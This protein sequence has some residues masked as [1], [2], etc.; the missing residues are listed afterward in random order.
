MSGRLSARAA[1]GWSAC[2]GNCFRQPGGYLPS[3]VMATQNGQTA[4]VAAV[5]T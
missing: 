1:T 3:A 4:V 2:V 5:L